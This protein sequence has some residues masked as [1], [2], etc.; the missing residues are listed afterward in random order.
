MDKFKKKI[1]K[2]SEYNYRNF[3]EVMDAI[4]VSNPKRWA[5]L[6]A[7]CKCLGIDYSR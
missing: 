5:E 3:C 2:L 6:Y 7:E 4:K 1:K